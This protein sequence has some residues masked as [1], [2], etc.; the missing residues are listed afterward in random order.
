M[1]QLSPHQHLEFCSLLIAHNRWHALQADAVLAFLNGK[2]LD[3]V[4]MRQPTGFEEGEKGTL[5]CKLNQS[6][7]GLTPSA[8][9]WYD[10]LAENLKKMGFRTRMYDSGLLIH[11]TKPRLYL[12]THVDHFKIVAQSREE[13]QRVLDELKFQLDI[14][15]LGPVKHYPGTN[16]DIDEKVVS[17]TLTKYIDDLI[18]SFGLADAHP[19]LSP[20]D[21]G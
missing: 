17:I 7:C 18:D 16:V 20:L 3:T 15:D 1:R 9:I 2:L 21:S 8:R 10:T 6:L 5:V 14:K 19:T 13:A 12:T 4:Y 11:E